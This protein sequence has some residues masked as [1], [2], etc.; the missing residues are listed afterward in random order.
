MRSCYKYVLEI[1]RVWGFFCYDTG[2]ISEYKADP[3]VPARV[4]SHEAGRFCSKAVR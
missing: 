2:L 3:E 4:K 1:L